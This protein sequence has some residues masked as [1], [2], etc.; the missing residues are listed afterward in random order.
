ESEHTYFVY[1]AQLGLEVEIEK[2]F[3]FPLIK[4]GNS[5]AYHF[6]EPI[7]LILFPYLDGHLIPLDLIQHEA[8]LTMSY[9]LENRSYLEERENGKMKTD[10][11]YGYIYS[12]ALSVISKT[13]IFTPDIAPSPR[14][15]LD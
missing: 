14:F 12:K 3:L 15:S 9:L 4:G 5:K 2:R 6:S 8:P 10:K 13:K 11:W 1:S 7:L